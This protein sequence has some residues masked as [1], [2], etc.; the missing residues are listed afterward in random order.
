MNRRRFIDQLVSAQQE[1]F[2]NFQS[3]R[4]G[5]GEVDDKIVLGRLLNR[6]VG[7]LRSAQNL[8]DEVTGTPAE[9]DEGHRA[10]GGSKIPI[11]R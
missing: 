1:R 11:F 3:K 6:D 10:D 7:G 8:V 9:V 4:P 5:G 2:G